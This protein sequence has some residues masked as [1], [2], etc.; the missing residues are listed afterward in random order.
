MFDK[1]FTPR[2]NKQIRR[3]RTDIPWTPGME[4][5]RKDRPYIPWA[6]SVGDF[7]R[8]GQIIYHYPGESGVSSIGALAII[9]AIVLAIG[10]YAYFT[11][12]PQ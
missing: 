8:F 9:G 1:Y 11:S 12:K 6:H 5:V 4:I 2:I 10:A 7:D 3:G